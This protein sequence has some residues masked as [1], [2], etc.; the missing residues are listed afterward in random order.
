MTFWTFWEK[1]LHHKSGIC[2]IAY[3]FLAFGANLTRALS[4][5]LVDLPTAPHQSSEEEQRN[6]EVISVHSSPPKSH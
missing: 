4:D 2:G 5:A 3:N 1:W 6:T